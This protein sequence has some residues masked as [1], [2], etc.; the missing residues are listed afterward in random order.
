MTDVPN[1]PR[2]MLRKGVYY[3]R[4]SVPLDIR[5]TYPKTEEVFSLKTK[6]P[7]EAVK[8]VR[9]A[10]AE[11]DARFDE[12]RRRQNAMVTM[13]DELTDAELKAV[14]QAYYVHLLEEDDQRRDGGFYDGEMLEL[15]A[16]T[17]D[18]YA[19]NV[20]FGLKLAEHYLPRRASSEFY[21]DEADEVLSWD[22]FDISLSKSSISRKKVVA[23]IQRAEIKAY[24]DIALRN[25]GELIDTPVVDTPVV[26]RASGV[27]L[28][29]AAKAWVADKRPGWTDKTAK[30]NEVAIGWFIDLVGD[31]FLGGYTK[32]DGRAF[33]AALQ[34]LPANWTKQPQLKGLSFSKAVEKSAQLG[35]EPM[36][37]KNAAK[38][39]QFVG[40]FWTWA[41]GNYDEVSGSPMV[42]LSLPK[43]SARDE[44][45]AFTSDDLAA[46]FS[47]PLYRGC[48]SLHNWKQKGN[49]VPVD[50]GRYWVPLVGLYTGARLAEIVQLNVEDVRFE[51][52]VAYLSLM[53]GAE[54]GDDR[55]VKNANARRNIPIHSQLVAAG[56]LEFVQR[57]TSGKQKRLFPDIDKAADGT[58]SSAFSKWFGN[59]LKACGVKTKKNSF[60]SFRH[61]FEDA[62]RAGGVPMEYINAIQGHAQGGEADR[63]GNGGYPVALLK[64]QIEKV[65]L[66]SLR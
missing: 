30:A 44:R 5:D 65:R 4:A 19:E 20:A 1:H 58:Y 41:E 49:V 50:S 28:S 12:H 61:T 2:L 53:P 25:Q 24:K 47:A 32:A 27:M 3:H 14:E 18:E 54:E 45:D 59:F 56:F 63:Y 33:K 60:H 64:A 46:I 37:L 6:D 29:D 34:A 38:N 21:D 13:R 22:G 55:R 26:R 57:A 40:A 17:F 31:R 51:G 48:L 62:C 11:V 7:R 15:P 23:A 66:V 16:P 42:K 35:L 9:K 52:D 10:A 36:S 43:S 39:M 8:L